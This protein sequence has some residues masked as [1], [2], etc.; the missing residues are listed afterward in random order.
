MALQT[1][2]MYDVLTKFIGYV[3]N[4]TD[5]ITDWNI[6]SAARTLAEAIAVQ[7]EEF[8][9]S[10]QQNVIW[11]IENGIYEAFGFKRKTATYA[12]GY[13]SVVLE[14]YL[15]SDYFIDKGTIFNT[16]AE[17]GYLAFEAVED[18]V[19]PA[20][21]LSA[22]IKV[23]CTKEGSIGNID[24]S[25]LCS[26]SEVNTTISTV[27]N[28]AAFTNGTD[29]ETSTERRKRF[30]E[31]VRNLARGTAEAITYAALQVEGITGV[32]VDDSYIGY[33]KLYAHDSDGNL[34]DEL[35]SALSSAVDDYRSAGI[36][37]QVLSIIKRSVDINVK[38]MLDDDYDTDVYNNS[39]KML[40]WRLLYEYTVSQ[41]LYIA[42]LIYNIKSAYSDEV[43]NIVTD[44]ED[45][46]INDNELIRP[47]NITVTCINVS[48]WSE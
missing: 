22:L 9:Y 10:M 47:N 15:P 4:R 38:V 36:E 27:Y 18:T 3:T 25:V 19:I 48:D 20:G 43:I 41:S 35:K 33:C 11:A 31:Y 40:I 12:S 45:I 13:V 16:S 6:G 5:K 8:Y 21:E 46:K 14:D 23:R 42:D 1:K 7:F 24:S 17:T 37:V 30:Q 34:S 32:W 26:I 39:I 44:N 28:S 2:S 29:A